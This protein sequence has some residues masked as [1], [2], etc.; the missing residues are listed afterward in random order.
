[1]R[2]KKSQSFQARAASLAKLGADGSGPVASRMKGSPHQTAAKH[3]A[4]LQLKAS[5]TEKES[6]LAKAAS[7]ALP[8]LAPPGGRRDRS[9]NTTQRKGQGQGQVIHATRHLHPSISC[10]QCRKKINCIV[11]CSGYASPKGLV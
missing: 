10:R 3:I 8:E 6:K 4:R 5:L 1:M 7:Q 2:G 11:S 9:E